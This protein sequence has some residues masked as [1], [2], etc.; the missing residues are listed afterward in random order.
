V[1]DRPH[2][3]PRQRRSDRP[4]GVFGG[5]WRAVLRV[6]SEIVNDTSTPRAMNT[7]ARVM[8]IFAGLLFAGQIAGAQPARL[9]A[10]PAELDLAV[11]KARMRGDAFRTTSQL[12]VSVALSRRLSRHFGLAGE[13][14]VFALG[15][16]SDACELRGDGSGLCRDRIAS[17]VHLSLLG[18]AMIPFRIVEFRVL[19][20]PSLALSSRQPMA[21]GVLRT[22]LAFGRGSSALV[23]S[24]RL[25]AFH[26]AG[27]PALRV[28][29]G[30]IGLRFR[31]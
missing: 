1:A 10:L 8:T 9:D 6:V 15:G 29:S 14:S 17:Q 28:S 4:K 11:G 24:H 5:R 20:G 31:M 12:S 22:D 13:T 2:A 16:A 25:A 26:G 23:M 18:A 3:E 27:S 30:A 21:G 7:T 19:A